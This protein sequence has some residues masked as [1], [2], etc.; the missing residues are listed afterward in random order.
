MGLRGRN[1][2]EV[3]SKGWSFVNTVTN[4]RVLQ[5]LGIFCLPE[6]LLAFQSGITTL[7]HGVSVSLRTKINKILINVKYYIFRLPEVKWKLR[8]ANES[9]AF[10]EYVT[11]FILQDLSVRK[12]T[13]R[14]QNQRK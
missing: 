14:K 12:L 7:L 11:L 13:A 6:G 8:E 1:S 9:G 10:Y 5:I 3:R 4:L 2:S